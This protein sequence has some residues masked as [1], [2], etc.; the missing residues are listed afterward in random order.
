MQFSRPKR[1][2]AEAEGRAAAS[3]ARVRLREGRLSQ[4]DPAKVI[5]GGILRIA[6]ARQSQYEQDELLTVRM[7]RGMLAL[8]QVYLPMRRPVAARAGP[9][10]GKKPP[11]LLGPL[12]RIPTVWCDEAR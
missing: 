3:G 4:D 2:S 5:Y 12:A 7:L 11:A 9:G 6:S 10:T 8:Q 1:V